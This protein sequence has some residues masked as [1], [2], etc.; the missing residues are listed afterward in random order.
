[1]FLFPASLPLYFIPQFSPFSRSL[2][3]LLSSLNVCCI[4][5]QH[6]T[7]ALSLPSVSLHHYLCFC[8]KSKVIIIF[9]L[10]SS[11]FLPLFLSLWLPL[12]HYPS[13]TALLCCCKVDPTLGRPF[14]L[15]VPLSP[16]FFLLSLP[17]IVLFWP[18]RCATVKRDHPSAVPLSAYLSDALF[19]TLCSLVSVTVAS[20]L[21]PFFRSP[22]M[23][24]SCY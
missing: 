3:L 13:R 14:L 1:M 20:L 22:V 21:F 12:I 8:W 18:Q 5:I 9:L 7:F 10:S 6:F 19:S 2:H 4:H 23:R 16:P 17:P 11:S 24:S 15:T